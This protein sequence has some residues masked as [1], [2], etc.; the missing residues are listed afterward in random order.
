MRKIAALVAL[1]AL[2][3]GAVAPVSAATGGGGG[4]GGVVTVSLTRATLSARVMVTVDYAFV[5]PPISD[6]LNTNV[7]SAT[8]GASVSVDQASGRTIA[9]ASGGTTM[10]SLPATCDGTTVNH[11][12]LSVVSSTVPFHG[13]LAAVGISVSADD[14]NC[15]FC[16]GADFG[17]ILVSARL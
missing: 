11:G 13:G 8:Y 3:V 1:V 16:G 6:Y 4:G 7:T 9:H 17:S 10:P 15:V 12:S 5:C 2:L 14:A